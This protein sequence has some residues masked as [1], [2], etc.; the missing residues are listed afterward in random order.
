MVFFCVVTNSIKMLIGARTEGYLSWGKLYNEEYFHGTQFSKIF[1]VFHFFFFVE[2]AHLRR[3][4][5]Y[6]LDTIMYA[7]KDSERKY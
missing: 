2:S 5:G 4:L 6:F 7:S 3:F 1:L